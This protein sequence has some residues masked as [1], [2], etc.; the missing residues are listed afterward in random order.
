MAAVQNYSALPFVLATAQFWVQ[1]CQIMSLLVVHF[2]VCCT[3]SGMLAH[4]SSNRFIQRPILIFLH[5]SSILV[6]CFNSIHRSVW[7]G[8]LSSR[9]RK[10][11]VWHFQTQ[12]HYK[13]WCE[14]EEVTVTLWICDTDWNQTENEGRKLSSLQTANGEQDTTNSYGWLCN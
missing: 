6:M 11:N 8:F 14:S 10:Q 4:Y 3:F 7:K 12:D 1:F 13:Y 2:Q 5:V 9:I